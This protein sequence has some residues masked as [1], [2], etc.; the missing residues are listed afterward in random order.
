MYETVLLPFDGSDGAAEALHHAGE[1]AH[2]ADAT[3]QVLYVA[4]TARNSVTV[5]KGHTV[6]TLVRKGEDIVAEVAQT[7]ETP[8]VSCDTDAVQ[9][10]PAP[11]TAE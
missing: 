10:H 7:L 5:V 8:G 11:S 1:L 3:V 6:D 9:G 4:D 2:W